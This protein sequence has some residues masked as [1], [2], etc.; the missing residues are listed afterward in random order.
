MHKEGGTAAFNPNVLHRL[1]GNPDADFDLDGFR[2]RAIWNPAESRT[3]ACRITSGFY[4]IAVALGKI[5]FTDLKCHQNTVRMSL[6]E[7]HQLRTTMDLLK[8]R[9]QFF[10]ESIR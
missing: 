1:N 3:F 5:D 6:D 8:A 4:A 2:N 9:L 7:S 10:G